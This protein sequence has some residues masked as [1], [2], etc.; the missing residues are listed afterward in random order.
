[1]RT[2]SVGLRLG[3]IRATRASADVWFAACGAAG[4]WS[5]HDV[6]HIAATLLAPDE[7]SHLLR[8]RR[9]S[10]AELYV[11]TRALVRSVLA[12]HLGL[13]PAEIAVTRTETGKPVVAHAL[14]FNV[15]HSGDL[16]LLALS[17]QRPVGVDVERRRPLSDVARLERRWLTPEERH[18]L[19]GLRG[20]GVDESDAFLRVWSRKEARLKALGVG[21]AGAA[22]APVRDVEALPLDELLASAT[23][24]AT[25]RAWSEAQYVGAIAF[26]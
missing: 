10:A 3:T 7:R 1:M 9:Q 20:A 11:L 25:D 21:I 15:S 26:A 6:T 18:E 4:D 16:I 17:E 8:Y 19:A 22:S 13:S 12:T 5:E 24:R 14:H 23:P 2:P